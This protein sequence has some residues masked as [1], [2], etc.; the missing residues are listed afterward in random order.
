M[1]YGNYFTWPS[2][3]MQTSGI[4]CFPTT[5]WS[6]LSAICWTICFKVLAGFLNNP[7]ATT[8]CQYCRFNVG[9]EYLA[10][11]GIK[12]SYRWR[13]IGFICAYIL[14]N[15]YAMGL[16]YYLFRVKVWTVPAWIKNV[17]KKT[18]PEAPTPPT[19]EDEIPEDIYKKQEGDEEAVMSNPGSSIGTRSNGETIEE[20]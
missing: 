13:N 4:Q 12:Y 2:S 3:C 5:N 18:I 6:H 10:T 9:D 14:F 7:N 1:L 16:L 11:L 19:S 20:K 15:V 8:N 17:K